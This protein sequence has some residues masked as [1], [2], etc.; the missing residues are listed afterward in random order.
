[1]KNSK[2]ASRKKAKKTFLQNSLLVIASLVSFFALGEIITRLVFGSPLITQPDNVLFW[3]YKA[4]QVGHQKLYSPVSTVDKNG[5]RYSGK[6]FSPDLPSIYVGGDSYAWGEG[7]L[8]RETFAAQLQKVL[9]RNNLKYNLLN[10]GVPAYGIGQIID[11]MEIECKKYAPEYAIFM[12]VET[13][14]NRLRDVSPEQKA[15]F[16]RDYRIR[17]MF[18]YSAFLKV[19]KEQLFE[20]LLRT[21][22]GFGYHGD[23]TVVY[24]QTHEFKDKVKGLTSRIKENVAF[25]KKRDIEPIWVITTIASQ[26][27]REYLSSLSH[28]LSVKFID[29]VP[30]YKEHFPGFKN[31]ATEHSGHFKPRVYG[32]I[33]NETFREVFEEQISTSTNGYE[34]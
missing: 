23:Q 28:E 4:N 29:P 1:M 7:V 3:K 17:A 18:R 13:D 14:I 6:E 11:R 24:E 25:L 30:L 21:D 22:I 32:L 12:W 15:K 33:V 10:G 8:D 9:D 27:F 19:I 5:F 20:K 34:R 16:L 26:D 2:N 31:M